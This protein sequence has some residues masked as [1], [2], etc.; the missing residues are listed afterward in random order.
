MNPLTIRTLSSGGVLS[1]YYCSSRCGH[2]L[3]ASSPRWEKDYLS[4]DLALKLFT[5][6]KELGCAS[7]HIG[8]G[9][10][11]LNLPG[12]KRVLQVALEIGMAVEYIETNSSWFKDED[13]AADTLKTIRDLGVPTLL[14]SISPFHNEYIPF[15][16]VKGVVKA[17]AWA[18]I[19]VFPWVQGFLN[20]LKSFP[21]HIPHPFSEYEQQFGADYLKILPSRYWIHLGGR[22][23]DTFRKVIKKNPLT[24]LLLFK[25]GCFELEDVSHFHFDPYGNYIPGMCSGVCID[26]QDLGS[27]LSESKY[28]FITLLYNQG[29]TGLYERAV[30][31]FGFQPRSHYISKCELCQDIRGFLVLQ[32]QVSTREFGPKQ[33]YVESTV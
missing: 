24:D 13:S 25:Q 2:C 23:F 15:Y 4:E 17:C 31:E 18:G 19:S 29:P 12:L 8:G 1:N 6:I 20:D 21:D 10:P 16:K 11:F 9:E 30:E 26:Y 3:Y 7:V 27:P 5:R 28:P 32:K 22:A 33:F 14:I